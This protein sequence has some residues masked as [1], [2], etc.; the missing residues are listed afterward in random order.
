MWS[1]QH[2]NPMKL[3]PHKGGGMT[4]IDREKVHRACRHSGDEFCLVLL[5]VKT[6][7]V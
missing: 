5:R 2:D 1:A 3:A 7:T 6:R 4:G